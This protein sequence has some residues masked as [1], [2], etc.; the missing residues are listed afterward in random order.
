LKDFNG[1]KKE[2]N[3]WDIV[4]VDN[5]DYINEISNILKEAI[6]DIIDS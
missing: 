2:N 6:Q 1:K 5:N 3:Q 4:E